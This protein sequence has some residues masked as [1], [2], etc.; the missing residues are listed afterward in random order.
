MNNKH[1][2]ESLYMTIKEQYSR[3]VN[4]DED[5]DKN[6][7]KKTNNYYN[8]I[9]NAYNNPNMKNLSEVLS[10]TIGIQKPEDKKVIDNTYLYVSG[11]R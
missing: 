6:E 4:E 7:N 3:T 8:N 10:E 5:Q 2:Y 11:F 1:T 9:F